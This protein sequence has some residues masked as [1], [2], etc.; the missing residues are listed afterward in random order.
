MHFAVQKDVF[1]T[2][3]Y[4]KTRWRPGLR[5]GPR[6]RSLRPYPAQRLR[7]F[8]SRAF[9]APILAPSTLNFGV[10]IVVNLRNDHCYRLL[11]HAAEWY[12]HSCCKGCT[13]TSYA[14]LSYHRPIVARWGT[15]AMSWDY[16]EQKIIVFISRLGGNCGSR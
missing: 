2:L 16:A 15:V 4:G 13:M 12:R 7:R 1:L 9:G 11:K 14:A 6:W 8:D 3:K 10:P 5:P